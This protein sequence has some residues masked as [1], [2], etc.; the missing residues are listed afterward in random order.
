MILKGTYIV[1]K[2][3]RATT[4]KTNGVYHATVPVYCLMCPDLSKANVY[5][6]AYY[7]KILDFDGISWILLDTIGSRIPI[8][9]SCFQSVWPVFIIAVV[10]IDLRNF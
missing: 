9:S 1:S 8:Q 3:K 7:F 2:K 6:V 4:D 10:E 5:F